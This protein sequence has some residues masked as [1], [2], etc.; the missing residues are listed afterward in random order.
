MSQQKPPLI[1][2]LVQ[3]SAVSTAIFDCEIYGNWQMQVYLRSTL[4]LILV[5]FHS[6]TVTQ[7]PRSITRTCS[8]IQQL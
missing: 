1:V 5:K 6:G 3:V 4:K 8:A 7:T 2:K